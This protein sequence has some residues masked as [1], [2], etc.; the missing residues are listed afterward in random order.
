MFP[1][2]AEVSP[3]GLEEEERRTRRQ[4]AKT[5]R[6]PSTTPPKTVKAPVKS[7]KNKVH[8]EHKKRE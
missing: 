4:T 2:E 6:P 1:F 5:E 8:A 3:K 7:P